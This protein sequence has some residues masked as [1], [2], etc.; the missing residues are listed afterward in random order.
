[1]YRKE[2]KEYLT[3]SYAIENWSKEISTGNPVVVSVTP[4]DD[5]RH[6]VFIIQE[7][8][9]EKKE[10][11][12]VMDVFFNKQEYVRLIITADICPWR[13]GEILKGYYLL[14]QEEYQFPGSKNKS[15]MNPQ[16]NEL[17]LRN[18]KEVYSRVTLRSGNSKAI[19]TTISSEVEVMADEVSFSFAD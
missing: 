5:G 9:V 11:D 8:T 3:N 10:G 17:V 12:S 1:M 4:T 14:D 2:V 6:T 15:K 13:E 18:G 16:K 7:G 19:K